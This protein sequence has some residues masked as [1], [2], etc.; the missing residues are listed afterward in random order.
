M[1]VAVMA[2][3]TGFE[4]VK[5]ETL[6]FIRGNIVRGVT[7]VGE[8][9]ARGVPVRGEAQAMVPVQGALLEFI[10]AELLKRG[11]VVPTPWWEE[12]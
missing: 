12:A 7:N 4:H 6:W 11:E 8:A 10:D 2:T 5:L 9:L 1:W 3:T